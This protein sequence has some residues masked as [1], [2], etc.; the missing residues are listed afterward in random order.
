MTANAKKQRNRFHAMNPLCHWCGEETELA[1]VVTEPH[2]ATIDHLN[3]RMSPLRHA[4]QTYPYELRHVLSCYGCN[5]R[6]AYEERLASGKSR[7]LAMKG[8]DELQRI[9]ST[10]CTK[11]PKAQRKHYS[12]IKAISSELTWRQF[13]KGWDWL[14]D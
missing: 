8:T 2:H 7:T 3:S 6:R 12:Q 1:S 9:L 11:P 13:D 5:Q 10:L 4:P 14:L